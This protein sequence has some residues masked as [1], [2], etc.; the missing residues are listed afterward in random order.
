[1]SRSPVLELR[2][3]VK[4][5]GEVV[6]VTGASLRVAAGEVHALVGENG[7]GK[8]TL[9]KIL[10]GAI[11]SDAGSVLVDGAETEFASP[12]DAIAA[13]V[14]MIP[15]ALQLVPAMTVAENIVLG[16]EPTHGRTPFVDRGA[17][18]RIARR[19]LDQI[20]ET[21]DVAAP[22]GGLSVARR[23]IVE[24]ARAI[25]RKV[26]ILALDEPT[27]AL[28]SREIGGLFGLIRRLKGEGV[29]ILYISHRLD[30]IFEIADRVTILRDGAVVAS[31]PTASLDRGTM[32]RHMVGRE[33]DEAA[34]TA[35]AAPGDELLRLDGVSGG[36]LRDIDFVLRRGEIVGLAGLVGAGRT[37]LAR[38]I[39]G[40]D[41]R[42][43]GRMH[44]EGRP[45]DPRSPREA[46]D[47]G[48]G[49]LTE[50]RDRLG[51]V[52]D[53]NVR[54]NITL[55]GLRALCQGPFIDAKREREAAL[56]H[57]RR[58]RI[59]ARSVDARVSELSGGN[60]QKVVLAR[61]LEVRSR[62]LIFDE[63][64]AGVD[65]GARA[66]IHALLRE[67]AASGTG[68][69]VVS[70][71]LDELLGLCDRIA[72]M[73]EGRIAGELGRAEATRGAIIHLAT[74]RPAAA[75]GA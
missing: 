2:G 5:Y 18:E 57:A 19:A 73:C 20:G 28:S 30:E 74:S 69:I 17:S 61:W 52:S 39:F 70:S 63:P 11:R 51:L 25:S 21:M 60:R 22:V 68:V 24:I 16:S 46:I 32:I 71:D 59:K 65:V 10:A 38:A 23:Q 13:G 50:D 8:S 34:R 58:L 35:P 75:A 40:A 44:L 48:I 41:P 6:A 55:A 9:M 7:A 4:R 15:Q 45:I 12:M 26:R 49:L 64:T 67:L 47:L 42:S 62:V 56:G 53:L 31:E 27:A 1:M 3:I 14:G 54:Q 33:L 66:E 43:G 29:A 36:R 37:E 72:V